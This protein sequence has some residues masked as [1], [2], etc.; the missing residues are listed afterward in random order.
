MRP[1]VY[2]WPRSCEARAAWDEFLLGESLLV[3]PL[4]EENQTRRT[5]WLPQGGWYS[6]FTG[7]RF[8][9]WQ[10]VTAGPEL[11]FPVFLREG[12]ALALDLPKGAPLGADASPDT[13]VLPR[14][15]LA[16]EAGEYALR[17]AP[18]APPLVIRWNGEQVQLPAELAHAEVVR[19][20]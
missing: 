17:T 13:A 5:L 2:H 20:R 8:E 14:L 6:L 3:A 18:D 7:Q 10:T 9:G 19:W 1:L 11:T 12:C 15:V 16:G 4:L